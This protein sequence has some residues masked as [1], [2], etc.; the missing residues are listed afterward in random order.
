[1]IIQDI[2][3]TYNSVHE[4]RFIYFIRFNCKENYLDNEILT[5]SHHK[6]HRKI[7]SLR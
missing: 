2:P 7:S 3:I 5:Y 6:K 4:N 1:M